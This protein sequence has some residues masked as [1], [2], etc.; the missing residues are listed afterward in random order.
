MSYGYDN[1]NDSNNNNNINNRI[2][3][4]KP[5]KESRFKLAINQ[6]IQKHVIPKRN[7]RNEK[8]GRKLRMQKTNFLLKKKLFAQQTNKQTNK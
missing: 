5:Q 7:I 6:L 3:K 4:Y 8:K 2:S 1:N